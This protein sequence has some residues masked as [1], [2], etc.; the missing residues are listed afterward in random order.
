MIVN[1]PPFDS[2]P[3]ANEQAMLANI[4]GML[5]ENG[6]THFGTGYPPEAHS[7]TRSNGC[8]S[9]KAATLQR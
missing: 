8:K 9:C 6:Y 7:Q 5:D 4:D 2:S 3:N 1:H